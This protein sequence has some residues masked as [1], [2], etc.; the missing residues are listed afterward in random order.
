MKH[1]KLQDLSVAELVERYTNLG[2]EQDKAEL[3]GKTGNISEINRLF[4][5]MQAI[6]NEL[7]GRSGDERR[8]LLQLYEHPN[9][10]VRLKAAKATLAVAPQ[11]ARQM[12]QTIA[13]SRLYPAAGAA[14]MCLWALDEGIFVPS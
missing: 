13:D 5:Q 6:E 3:E 2:I 1:A 10:H 12:I 14:G 7:K 11:S 8:A 9:L 4:K